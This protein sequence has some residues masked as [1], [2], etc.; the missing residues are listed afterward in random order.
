MEIELSLDQALNSKSQTSQQQSEKKTENEEILEPPNLSYAYDDDDII[1]RVNAEL[2]L[3]NN[4][5]YWYD[6]IRKEFNETNIIGNLSGCPIRLTMSPEIKNF[7]DA[8]QKGNEVVIAKIN[9]KFIIFYVK[10]I[11]G[12][13]DNI[14]CDKNLEALFLPLTFDEKLLIKSQNEELYALIFESIVLAGGYTPPGPQVLSNFLIKLQQQRQIILSP[15]LSNALTDITIALNPII[16]HIQSYLVWVKKQPLLKDVMGMRLLFPYKLDGWHWNLGEV[17]FVFDKNKD[18]VS[19][20]AVSHDPFGGGI[21]QEKLSL[22]MEN[23]LQKLVDKSKIDI[24]KT[25]TYKLPRQKKGVYCGIVVARDLLRRINNLPLDDPKYCEIYKD[26]NKI[27][28]EDMSLLKSF[29]ITKFNTFFIKQKNNNFDHYRTD[30]ESEAQLSSED[31]LSLNKLLKETEVLELTQQELHTLFEI[32]HQIPHDLSAYLGAL[33]RELIKYKEN[34]LSTRQEKYQKFLHI[35][36]GMDLQTPNKE[37]LKPE[38]LNG[39]RIALAKQLMEVLQSSKKNATNYSSCTINQAIGSSKLPSSIPA[40]S[41]NQTI[42][43]IRVQSLIDSMPEPSKP[44]SYLMDHL[45]AAGFRGTEYQ[46]LVFIDEILKKIVANPNIKFDASIEKAGYGNLDD[47]AIIEKNTSDEAIR[48]EAYQCKYYKEPIII[49]DFLNDDKPQAKIP[50]AADT[51]N[52]KK[53]K[54]SPN[55]KKIKNK[56]MHIGKFFLGWFKWDSGSPKVPRQDLHSII[57][58]N[59]SIDNILRS[60]LVPQGNTFKPTFISRKEVIH[61]SPKSN[62]SMTLNFNF[63]K[64][65]SHTVSKKI[66]TLLKEAGYIN[67]EGTFTE[68]LDLAE[69]KFRLELNNLPKDVTS[70]SVVA[71]LRELVNNF[72]KKTKDLYQLLYDQ[73]WIYLKIKAPNEKFPEDEAGKHELFQSFL[74]SVKFQVNQPSLAELETRIQ[75]NLNT[76]LKQQSDQIFVCLFYA[77]H[78]WFSRDYTDHKV[79]IFTQD[80]MF[81]LLEQSKTRSRDV[82]LLQGWTQA[83]LSRISYYSRQRWVWRS[84]LPKIQEFIEKPGVLLMI[85]RKGIGKSSLVKK[86]L[87]KLNPIE[88]LVLSASDL[89]NDDSLKVMLKNALHLIS[90]IRIVIIDSAEALSP[91]SDSIRE[92]FKFLI[93][94]KKTIVLTSTPGIYDNNAIQK[95]LEGHCETIVIEPLSLNDVTKS[96][97]QLQSFVRK[98]SFATLA[99]IPFYIS[100]L[101]NLTEAPNINT[102]E[103]LVEADASE[104]ESE[105][106]RSDIA[107]KSLGNSSARRLAWHQLAFQIASSQY[108]ISKGIEYSKASVGLTLLMQDDIV[109][110][111]NN[112]YLFKHDLYFEHGLMSFWTQK[113]EIACVEGNTCQFWKE[114]PHSLKIQVSK[115]ALDEWLLIH[116]LQLEED[117]L[118]QVDIIANMEYIN[119]IIA[120]AIITESQQLLAKYLSIKNRNFDVVLPGFFYG[121]Y[122]ATLIMLAI[123]EKKPT[124]LAIL[125]Q[126]GLSPHHPEAKILRKLNLL[127]VCHKLEKEHSCSSLSSE[128]EE[129]NFSDSEIS[130]NLDS[131]DSD[132][133]LSEFSQEEDLVQKFIDN[134]NK[135]WFS[136]FNEDPVEYDFDGNWYAN[137]KFE[138][139]PSNMYSYI[140]QAAIQD[141]TYCLIV[142]LDSFNKRDESELIELTN[143][144]Q[145]TPLH[146]AVL[147]KSKNAVD[148]LLRR[149][150][151]VNCRDFWDETP[152]HNAAYNGDVEIAKK[153]LENGADP[154]NVNNFGLSPAHIAMVRL[155]FPLVTLF[156]EYGADFMLLTFEKNF[157]ESLSI[158]DLLDRVNENLQEHIEDFVIDLIPLFN[159]GYK[160]KDYNWGCN[161]PKINEETRNA[162]LQLVDDFL[163]FV[164]N[165]KISEFVPHFDYYDADTRLTYIIQT[166]DYEELNDMEDFILEDPNNIAEVL[167]AENF[168]HIKEEILD[169]WFEVASEE[170]CQNLKTYGKSN[171]DQDVL[172]RC[173]E[174]EEMSLTELTI[175]NDTNVGTLQPINSSQNNI[176]ISLLW[177]ASESIPHLR[178]RPVPSAPPALLENSG[179]TVHPN[180]SA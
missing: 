12:N 90:A 105:L 166:G 158:A 101:I 117:L 41:S 149:G 134:P 44:P 73:T 5:Y 57:I 84:E 4:N 64:E 39:Y 161:C 42:D 171:N 65:K 162:Q 107:G 104:L 94:S 133:D 81:E 82:V 136:G 108:G 88:Y 40:V 27:R 163:D 58:S 66:W 6:S 159:F 9:G 36:Y 3:K 106:I 168:A 92:L 179:F 146:V 43:P 128:S 70:E 155:N 120:M 132:K 79:P 37:I 141:M 156:F 56:K 127:T 19:C 93:Q 124:A 30:S 85:G 77:V 61:F 112:H 34:F 25:S 59:T 96:F 74:A 53:E 140:H 167:T 129:Q 138:K 83:C 86:V 31:Q 100:S 71:C 174:E 144:Y 52:T 20:T 26:E 95:L 17:N 177:A 50:N 111:K 24:N 102:V 137:P 51:A 72:N 152:L 113:W 21:I 119:S 60:C 45:L 135:Y 160:T 16:E 169:R 14:T 38:V 126:N 7:A 114:I 78:E 164:D 15:A 178:T 23:L 173:V 76:I 75:K 123:S 110:Q 55:S 175:N 89:L 154:N 54:N 153:L 8:I 142:L 103:N 151:N 131:D 10:T 147:E 99:R 32:L 13:I 118:Q 67:E 35:I 98:K 109:T 2:Q 116:R 150:A 125:L 62:Y 87:E 68:L 121:Y 91:F 139:R 170:Q 28:T 33:K 172:E 115:A 148:V 97:P 48:I 47:I 63:Y 122:N 165:V 145:E 1:N 18:I 176:D 130:S 46:L 157:N 22:L 80:L 11:N 180:K 69:P 49:K 143:N 29:D